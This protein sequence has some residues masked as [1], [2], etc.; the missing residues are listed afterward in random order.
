MEEH[1]AHAS[2]PEHRLDPELRQRL[3]KRI[4]LAGIAI[5]ALLGGL[6]VI[7]KFYVPPPAV[8]PR[9]VTASLQSVKVPVV[10]PP[11]AAAPVAAPPPP[12]EIAAVPEQSASPSITNSPTP[13]PAQTKSAEVA[14]PA[15]TPKP[16][17]ASTTAVPSPGKAA[18]TPPP[19]AEDDRASTKP[20]A[21]DKASPR[22][23]VFQL[24][25]FNDVANA[26]RLN[27]K[28]KEGGVPSRIEARV[29]VGPFRTRKEAEDARKKLVELGIEPGTLMPVRK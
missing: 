25:I 7:D 23:Y 26:Q 17:I 24:G 5:A 14:K 13:P 29:Q 22:Q 20:L 27:E 16:A 10:P 3:I 18:A 9:P 8:V 11:A 12:P 15:G 19:I 28:L 6:A 1:S 2:P 4:A 21:R